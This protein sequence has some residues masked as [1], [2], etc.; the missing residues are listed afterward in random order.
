MRK[1]SYHYVPKPTKAGIQVSDH[2]ILRYLERIMNLDLGIPGIIDTIVSDELIAVINERGDGDYY[3]NGIKYGV[4][5]RIIT[6]LMPAK[7]NVHR[8]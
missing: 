8:D 4:R 3:V 5:N 7:S 2:A 1:Y 6:T